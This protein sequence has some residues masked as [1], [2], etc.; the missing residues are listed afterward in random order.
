MKLN[1]DDPRLTAYALG[2]LPA[3]ERAD[4]EAELKNNPEC[5]QI[6]EEIRGAAKVLSENF[7]T[8]PQLTLFP[9]Q[10]GTIEEKLQPA[11]VVRFPRQKI[12]WA[13]GLAAA[14]C[15]AIMAIWQAGVFDAAKKT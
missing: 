10:R 12:Y 9:E 1:Q 15:V 11:N 8:E 14:A 13:A 4:I 3:N 5:R 6:V 2:E 7:A